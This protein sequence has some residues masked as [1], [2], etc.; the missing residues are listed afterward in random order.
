MQ[1]IPF[2]NKKNKYY[3]RSNNIYHFLDD[4]F[5]R[6]CLQFR[7]FVLFVVTKKRQIRDL[8]NK[9]Y[10][11]I[12]YVLSQPNRLYPVYDNQWLQPNDQA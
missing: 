9:K 7:Q 6:F 4:I 3:H 11:P 12:K 1:I 8:K 2:S 10:T 5:I